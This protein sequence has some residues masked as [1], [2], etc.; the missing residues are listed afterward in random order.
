MGDCVRRCNRSV[1]Y[2]GTSRLALGKA[3]EMDLMKQD[4]I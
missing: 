1:H 4:S 2:S 3:G